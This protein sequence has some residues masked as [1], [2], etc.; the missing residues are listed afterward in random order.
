MLDA[1]LAL[2]L[3]TNNAPS[4]R[5]KV[6]HTHG[7]TT[8]SPQRVHRGW[9]VKL[10]SLKRKGSKRAAGPR[11]GL[12]DVAGAPLLAVE[13]DL[14]RRVLLLV[15]SVVRGSFVIKFFF[16]VQPGVVQMSATGSV[17][18]SFGAGEEDE[19][20]AADEMEACG[21]PLVLHWHAITSH[22]QSEQRVTKSSWS[23]KVPGE[24]VSRLAQPHP[25]LCLSHP[26]PLLWLPQ[27]HLGPQ[28][29]LRSQHRLCEPQ[30]YMSASTSVRSPASAVPG[31]PWHRGPV[32]VSVT[33]RRAGS[34]LS[35]GSVEHHLC[36]GM[37]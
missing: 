8:E 15:P 9:S 24:R 21:S 3:G 11:H 4:S 32:P 23:A 19:V 22:P 37:R 30:R 12:V 14:L 31:K 1:S 16:S 27:S 6:R 34:A 35:S 26:Q 36:R 29:H 25:Q 33:P 5:C 17:G 18:D 13:A 10:H 28:S 7:H 2:L 20:E